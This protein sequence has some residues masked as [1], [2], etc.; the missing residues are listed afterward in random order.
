MSEQPLLD[1]QERQEWLDALD[2][3]VREGGVAAGEALINALSQHAEIPVYRCL[4]RLRHH[5]ATP[6]PLRTSGLCLAI[7]LWSAAYAL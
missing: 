7:C 3:V 1:V 5:F 2:S 4:W 6:S